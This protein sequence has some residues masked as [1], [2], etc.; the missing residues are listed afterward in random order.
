[1]R[2]QSL[3][4]TFSALLLAGLFALLA[5]LAP[6]AP[7]ALAAS[8]TPGNLVIYRVGNG[9][10]PLANTGNPVFLDEY[11][12]TGTLVQSLAL[13]TE[14][15]GANRRLI[16]NGADASEGLLTRSADGRYLVL[17]G[18]DATPPV[19]QGLGNTSALAV[20]RVIG[21][22]DA[23]GTINTFT[24]LSDS[25]DFGP[26]RSAASTNGTD[27]WAAGSNGGVRYAA[28]AATSSTRLGTVPDNV[29]QLHVFGGQLYA[30]C[31]SGDTEIRL[32]SVGSGTPTTPGQTFSSLP[33][34]PQ[35][36]GN[37]YGFFMADLAAGV[38]GLDTLYVA[39]N[40][41]GQVRKY[42]LEGGSWALIA[43]IQAA[44]VRGLTGA[45]S[46]GV[47]SLFA[48]NGAQ[49]LGFTDSTGYGGA[50]EGTMIQLAAAPANTA[51]RGVAL[52]PE[53]APDPTPTPADT[54]TPTGTRTAL[55]T[56][57]PTGTLTI[58]P[59]TTPTTTPTETPT[60]TA[61]ATPTNTATP[62][63]SPDIRRY[64]PLVIR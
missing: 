7:P 42:S 11:T 44:L 28:L 29:R 53:G 60:E 63:E 58:T 47:V 49:L 4:P 39:D 8:F 17:T 37:P 34:Y 46:G 45:V 24:A 13:P 25:A 62:G 43:S 22:V 10:E 32:G 21:R 12:T 6:P 3:S 41:L 56:Q 16:A 61:G 26:I 51:F 36:T 59:T 27:L 9:S 1:M 15:A 54:S 14:S 19:A 57:T 33:G 48:T 55:P 35:N 31:F 40:L 2:L 23:A 20:N 50:I 5:A 64:L 18:Y 30:S 38:A 52:A